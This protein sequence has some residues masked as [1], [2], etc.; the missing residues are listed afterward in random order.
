MPVSGNHK[1]PSKSVEIRRNLRTGAISA[2]AR[3]SLSVAC[4]TGLLLLLLLLVLPFL[5]VA[6]AVATVLVCC[7]CILGMAE[8]RS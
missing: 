3:F 6:A 2:P 1:K 7:C 4:R 8:P 5:F